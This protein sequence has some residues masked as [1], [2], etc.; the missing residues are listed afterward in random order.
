[1]SQ[2]TLIRMTEMREK[3]LR[4]GLEG[5]N[6]RINSGGLDWYYNIKGR[7][8]TKKQPF[9]IPT[10]SRPQASPVIRSENDQ[11]YKNLKPGDTYIDK[12]GN[13]RRKKG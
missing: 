5:V 9:E 10:Y 2:D 1:M 13:V 12:D 7:F 4:E 3:Y 8:G 6:E 11:A